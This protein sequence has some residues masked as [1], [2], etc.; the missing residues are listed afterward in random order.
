MMLLPNM[1][2]SESSAVLA[3]RPA[4]EKTEEIDNDPDA[5]LGIL[6]HIENKT[7]EKPAEEA[8]EQDT[9]AAVRKAMDE[10]T[11]RYS[12]AFERMLLKDKS[13][14]IVYLRDYGDMHEL[15]SSLMLKALMMAVE[16]VKQKGQ[17]LVIL[18][19]HSPSLA[20]K[21][22][23]Y[24]VALDEDEIP[25]MAG[26]KTISIVPPLHDKQLLAAWES[27][28]NDDMGKRIGEINAKQIL[29]ILKQKNVTGMQGT[30]ALVTE[31]LEL[32]GVQEEVWSNAQVERHATFAIGYALRQQRT[33][34]E[35]GDLEYANRV[36]SKSVAHRRQLDTLLE[37]QKIQLTEKLNLAE[38]KKHCDEYE[39]RF[40]SCIVDPCECL[41]HFRYKE[42]I[43]GGFNA[44]LCIKQPRCMSPLQIL[45][46]RRPQ[47]RRCRR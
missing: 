2:N 41:F 46:P 22:V 20:S 36:I 28:M 27:Q 17:R 34:V 18:A 29:A 13:P 19:G 39:Q 37:K 16:Q 23:N 38:L 21:H 9:S 8:S 3:I 44:D 1:S 12:S 5:I 11:A 30:A 14:K 6:E 26:M 45:G 7:D 4:V 40:L 24:K 35:Y 47:S 32:N 33:T 31:M 15:P 43:L 42:F 25:Q 10:M